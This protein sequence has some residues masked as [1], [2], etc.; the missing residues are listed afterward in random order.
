MIPREG[1]R[2]GW[3]KFFLPDKGYGFLVDVASGREFFFHYRDITPRSTRR[4]R[5]LGLWRGEYVEFETEDT[6]RGPVARR[7][8]GIAGGPLMCELDA[9]STEPPV[10]SSV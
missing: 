4:P 8:R 2:F 6:E 5:F 3:T 9:V 1:T 10:F 7:I